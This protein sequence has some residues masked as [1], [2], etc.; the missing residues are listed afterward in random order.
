[1]NF[2]YTTRQYG[3]LKYVKNAALHIFFSQLSP[4]FRKVEHIGILS[5]LESDKRTC[6][7]IFNEMRSS[8]DPN[9]A[10]FTTNLEYRLNFDDVF[11]LI[12]PKI[13]G[14]FINHEDKKWLKTA[15]IAMIQ[16]GITLKNDDS[17][18]P[19]AK[20]QRKQRVSFSP[21]FEQYLVY[22]E[23]QPKEKLTEWSK[24]HISNNYDYFMQS[25]EGQFYTRNL[26]VRD[27]E[28]R[29]NLNNSAMEIESSTNTNTKKVEDVYEDRRDFFGNKIRV[30]KTDSGNPD[31]RLYEFRFEF[32][33]GSNNLTKHKCQ[34]NE[35]LDFFN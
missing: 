30:K 33:E 20:F 29:Q 11:G 13:N 27:V 24:I 28:E 18:G 9:I 1:M 2:V 4:K 25:I 32:Q 15:I 7:N 14:R 8:V 3:V 6:A 26:Q 31:S 19:V 10:S 23:V 17:N 34:F 21:A 16:N 5:S 35:L 22:G 12:Q